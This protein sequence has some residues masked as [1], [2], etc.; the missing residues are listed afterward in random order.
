MTQRTQINSDPGRFKEK[1]KVSVQEIAAKF[2]SKHEIYHFLTTELSM[3]LPK[4]K[5]TSIYWM[6]EIVAGKRKCK[7]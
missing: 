1:K 6:R 3:Y 5:Q 4:Y 2:E 7:S